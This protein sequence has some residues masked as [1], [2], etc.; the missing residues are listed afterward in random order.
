MPPAG[1]NRKLEFE[2]TALGELP[3]LYRVARRLTGDAHQAEDLVAQALLD[4]AKGWHSF[5]GAHPRSWLIRILRNRYLRHAQREA[6][7]P[8]HVQLNEAAAMQKDIWEDLDWQMIGP[9]IL[10]ALD[11]LPEEYR[12][13]VSLCDVEQM[14]YEDA[15]LAMQV[16]IGT[17]RSRV[18]RGRRLLREKLAWVVNEDVS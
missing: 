1:A 10:D 17:V 3:V 9:K 12:T 7:K 11:E 18:F 5:D 2:Q 6:S 8:R 13:A 14:S 15:S 4:A 16:P